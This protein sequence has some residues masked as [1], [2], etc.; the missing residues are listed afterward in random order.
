MTT[1]TFPFRFTRAYQIAAAPFGVLPTTTRCTVHDGEL[2][3]RFG[4]WRVRTPLANIAAV[5]RTGPYSFA[6][7][8]GPAHLSLADRGLTFAT[9][10][11]AGACIRFI[12]P[13]PGIEPTGRLKHPGLTVTVDDV[14]GLITTLTPARPLNSVRIPKASTTQPTS[15]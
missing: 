12:E 1:Q 8:A 9:N 10:G 3:V 11:V 6:K 4:P 7:T 15:R 13:V 2:E 14:D 5:E